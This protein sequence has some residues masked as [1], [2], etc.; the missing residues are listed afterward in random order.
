MNEEIFHTK[1]VA[2]LILGDEIKY[3]KNSTLSHFEWCKELGISKDIYDSLVR[4]YA[5]NGDIVYYTGEFKY[6]ERVINTALNTYQKIANHLD[7]K[8]YSVYC[9][10]LKGKVGEIWKPILKIK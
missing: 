10:V 9:G 6:D 8:D 3:L 4:G 1:R 7:M 2:F 5:Y